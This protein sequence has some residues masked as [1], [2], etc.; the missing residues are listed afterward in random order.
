MKAQPKQIT[1]V[2]EDELSGAVID[3]ILSSYR[4]D[5]I[6]HRRIPCNGFGKIKKNLPGYNNSAK[7]SFPYFILTDLDT[8]V[9]A[10]QLIDDWTK[11]IPLNPNLLFRVAVREVESWILAD[12]ENIAKYLGITFSKIPVDTDSIPDPKQLICNLS[13]KS[14][15]KFVRE[16]IPPKDQY[17]V[18]GYDYNAILIYFIQSKWNI[19]NAVECSSSLK[20][21]V[22]RLEDW[23]KI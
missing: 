5:I 17:A 19:P 21:T 12:R 2:Y 16:G 15:K 20:R 7:P 9:C 10:P 6:V 4:P 22:E 18:Q 11:H 3:R 23:L 13:R 14:K 1:T 8:A